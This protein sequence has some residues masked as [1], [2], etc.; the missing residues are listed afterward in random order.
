MLLLLL[1]KQDMKDQMSNSSMQ[2]LAERKNRQ[3]RTRKGQCL[4][5]TRDS[6]CLL[7]GISCLEFPHKPLV[8]EAGCSQAVFELCPFG[9]PGRAG[10]HVAASLSQA[11][12]RAVSQH[13]PSVSVFRAGCVQLSALHHP[14]ERE[15]SLLLGGNGLRIHVNE[16]NPVLCWI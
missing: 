12:L 13:S 1:N 8:G 7:Q 6:V 9:C 2:A 14:M 3:V 5:A 11:S 16:C 4:S 10:S 15:I